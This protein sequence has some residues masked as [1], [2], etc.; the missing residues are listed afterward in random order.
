MTS[1]LVEGI[2]NETSEFTVETP[3]SG[4]LEVKVEGPKSEAKV[5]INN[6]NG[7]YKVSYNPTGL[8]PHHHFLLLSPLLLLLCFWNHSSGSEFP[9]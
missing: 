9:F 3:G 8:L 4:K 7:I 1:G 6:N 5:N 2:V